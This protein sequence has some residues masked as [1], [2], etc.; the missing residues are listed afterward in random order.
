[1]TDHSK[2]KEVAKAF[3]KLK[4]NPESYLYERDKVIAYIRKSE[5]N[6]IREINTPQTPDMLK[7]CFTSS[8]LSLQTLR[9]AIEQEKHRKD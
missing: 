4:E 3:Y 1:M 7:S 8:L 5:E 2:I 9:Y 6:L